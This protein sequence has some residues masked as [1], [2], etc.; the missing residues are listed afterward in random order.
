MD[1]TKVTL[2]TDIDDAVTFRDWLAQQP[3]VAVDTETTGLEHDARVRIIQVGNA[4][5]AF[6]IPVEEPRSYSALVQ[7]TLG[8]YD[9]DVVGHNWKFDEVRVVNTLGIRFSPEKIHDTMLQARVLEPLRSAAL[10]N[11]SARHVDSRAAAMQVDLAERMDGGKHTWATVPIDFEPYWFYGGLDTILTYRLDDVIRPQV[12]A[13]APN[14]YSLER[15]VSCV[16]SSMELHGALVDQEYAS[17]SFDSLKEYVRTAG[18]WCEEHYNVKPGSNA[19]VIK[20]LEAAGF[21]FD[22]ETATGAKALD[23]EVLGAID[24]PLAQVVLARRQAQKVANTYLKH[25]IEDADSDGRIHPSI[26]TCAAKTSRMSMSGPNLQNLPRRSETN[27]TSQMVRNS[28]VARPGYT[29]LMCDF[30]QIEWRLFASLAKDPKL[31]SAF[32]ADDFFTQMVREVFADPSATR[33]D[34]RRQTTKNAMYAR[35]Y[36]AG[37]AKFA[38]TA[39]ITEDDAKRFMALLDF[40]YPAIR[41]LTQEIER[42]ARSRYDSEGV[43]YVQSPMSRRQFMIDDN[44]WYKLTNY[45][46]Q[47]T[48]AEILKMKIVELAMAGLEDFLVCPVHDEIIL[49]VPD[50]DLSDVAHTVHGIMNDPD[51]FAVPLT[52]SMATGPSWGAKMD[53]ELER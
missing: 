42:M 8:R 24:H 14:A 17:A 31:Q 2:V 18:K 28:I 34:P 29:L 20:I 23:K 16:A 1:D 52:A 26:N 36:G 19:S 50:E 41:G 37:T 39:G 48:A 4:T 13:V 43:A 33:K 47:G 3:R 38:M 25:F 27:I 40:T 45:L 51:L 53:Y 30:D 10:K 15:T 22:K 12:E 5:E 32:Q 7:E 44:S 9:G 46:I 6:V 35:I 11:L 49:E 21:T